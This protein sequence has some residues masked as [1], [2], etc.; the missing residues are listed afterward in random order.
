MSFAKQTAL[1]RLPVVRKGD[2]NIINT[3]Y[4]EYALV[5]ACETV[6]VLGYKIEFIWLLS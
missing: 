1:I 6:P 4:N 5:Y 3:D 2:Y